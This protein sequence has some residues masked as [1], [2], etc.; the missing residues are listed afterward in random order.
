MRY[1]KCHIP[2]K[3]YDPNHSYCILWEREKKEERYFCRWSVKNGKNGDRYHETSA[4]FLKKKKIKE[5]NYAQ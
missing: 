5:E 2:S 1:T 4:E 3:D